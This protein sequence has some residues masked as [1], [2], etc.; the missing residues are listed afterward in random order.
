MQGS[1]QERVTAIDCLAEDSGIQQ[2]VPYFIQ[3][4]CEYVVKNLKEPK[5]L[6]TVVSMNFSLL[7]NK[8][9]FI[10]PYLHQIL[11]CVL[12]CVVGNSIDDIS[13]RKL[14]SE[15]VKYVYE[16]F[17]GVYNT[18]SPRN[19]NTLSRTWLD[20]NK[21]DGSQYG[22]LYCLSIL[23]ENVVRAVIHENEK[24]YKSNCNNETVLGLLDEIMKK[25]KK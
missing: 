6:K 15:V 13:V 20:P 8:F 3:Y 25:S 4:F 17:S 12:T 2:L 23:S 24:V 19:L 22:A 18:L 5:N 11:P 1:D 9:I 10:D 21:S 7:K 14:A 16:N